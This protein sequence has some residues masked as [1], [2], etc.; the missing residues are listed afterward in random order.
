[1]SE[2]ITVDELNRVL[3]PEDYGDV[4]PCCVCETTAGVRNV[5][6]LDA[7]APIAGHGWGC[8]LCDLPMDGAIAVVCDACIG[9]PLKFACRGYPGEEGRVPFAELRGTHQHNMRKHRT[10]EPYRL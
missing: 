2:F 8:V 7:K 6:M 10:P 5:M 3:E 4:G 9:Q 1:M